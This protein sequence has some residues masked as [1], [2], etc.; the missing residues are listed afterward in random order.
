MSIFQWP[1]KN[2]GDYKKETRILGCSS[3]NIFCS[4]KLFCINALTINISRFLGRRYS[5]EG[6]NKV[7]RRVKLF[8]WN[9]DYAT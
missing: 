9:L 1:E 5:T 7:T 2:G 4:T 6:G 3:L 8:Q